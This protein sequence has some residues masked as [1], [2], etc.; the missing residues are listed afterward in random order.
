[1]AY[2]SKMALE[3]AKSAIREQLEAKGEK[4]HK[5]LDEVLGF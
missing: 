5:E 1:M 2:N 3:A 4:L